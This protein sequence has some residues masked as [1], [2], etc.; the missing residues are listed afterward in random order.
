MSD[1]NADSDSIDVMQY[2]E[3]KSEPSDL[4]FRRK[5]TPTTAPS[6]MTDSTLKMV[7]HLSDSMMSATLSRPPI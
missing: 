1:K 4:H 3:T 7:F 2:Q 5:V 6:T